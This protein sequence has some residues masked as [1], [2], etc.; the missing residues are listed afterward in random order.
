[1]ATLKLTALYCTFDNIFIVNGSCKVRAIRGG[2][3]IL[4]LNQTAAFP[5]YDISVYVKLFY[6]YGTIYRPYLL[7]FNIDVCKI[8]DPNPHDL[9]KLEMVILVFMKS[10]GNLDLQHCPAA[11]IG[12]NLSWQMDDTMDKLIQNFKFILP[13]GDYK[14]EV[15]LFN[16]TSNHTYQTF[17]ARFNIKATSGADFTKFTMG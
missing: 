8:I 10:M 17:L 12:I 16:G 14:L 5:L 4:Q 15:R 11:P 7:N 3:G 13:A 9:A 2:V 6:K 1:M